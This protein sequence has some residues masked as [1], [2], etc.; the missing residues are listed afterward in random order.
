MK[1][2]LVT[3]ACGSI[4]K[5]LV[6]R[7]LEDGNT[8]CAFD[9]NEDGLFHLSKEC[10]LY[11]SSLK[12]FIGDVRDIKRLQQAM[13]GV[14][15]VYH[16]AALKH[17]ELS[18]YNPF[19][20]LKTNV[21]GTNNVINAAIDEG[22]KKVLVTSSD[23]AVNPSSTMGTTKLLAEKLAISANNYS[24]SKDI[25]FGC[26][27]FGNVWNTNGLLVPFSKIRFYLAKI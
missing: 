22:V 15:E 17:V 9:N 11:T 24:G 14:D 16:C 10:N 5:A 12:I 13:D 2:I 1:R 6:T 27:R 23:K 7:L 8:V 19:E 3:G 18:E 21:N 4:G 20:A 26:V 25:R